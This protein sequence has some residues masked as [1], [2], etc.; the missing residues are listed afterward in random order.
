LKKNSKD[1]YTSH[2]KI[3]IMNTIINQQKQYFNSN[4]TKPVSFRLAQLKKLKSV[5]KS[6]EQKLTEAVYND[7]QKGNFHTFLTEFAGVYTALNDAIKNLGKWSKIK[8]ASTSMVN[9]PGS[10]YII[11]EPLG[12]CLV[13]GS[14]NYPINLTLVPAIAAIA[15]GNTVVI[16]PSELSA[17]TSFALA[18]AIS[19]N[20][21]PSFLAVIQGGVD[22]TTDLLS[23]PFD[24]IFFTGSVSVGKIVYQ[25][26]AKNLVPVTLEL[27]G[28]SPLIIAPDANLKTTVR[29][30]V[31]GKF[32]NAG[33]TCVAPDYVMVHDSIKAKFLEILK[34]EIEKGA[35]ALENENYAQIISHRHFD[36]LISIIDPKKVVIGGDHDRTKRFI[37]PT[38]MIDITAED[39][40]MEDEIFGPIL[41]VLTYENIDQTISFIKSR[42]KP[43]SLYLFSES[44]EL[45]KKIWSELSFGGGMVN[46]VIMHFVNDP[47]PFGGVGNSGMGSYHGVA[48]FNSFSHFKS[49]MYRPTAFEFPLKYFP[50]SKLKFRLIKKTFGV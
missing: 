46:D 12:S 13:I 10:S 19:A 37:S 22:E 35:F 30:L 26:A 7:F 49:V 15:A 40:V 38:V 14:W 25:A 5:L 33:Q 8:R 4:I 9:F 32:V 21:D 41:P 11:P 39:K 36:R 29:R 48:G 43:L 28:K 27:G 31:W 18:D 3:D 45:R 20:F 23:Q 17:H 2:L 42:P 34:D 16:K 44:K 47:I 24:K 6:H 1:N 50:F